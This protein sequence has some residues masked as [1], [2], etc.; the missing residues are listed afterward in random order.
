MSHN[1][2]AR[3]WKARAEKAEAAHNRLVEAMKVVQDERDELR[4][5][6]ERL[7][8]ALEWYADTHHIYL[9][10]GQNEMLRQALYTHAFVSHIFLKEVET[11][12][13]A[14]EALQAPES[15]PK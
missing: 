13:R 11:G 2:D 3:A 10:D 12:Q 14:R 9:H 1:L 4:A 8:R 15:E 6:N 7:R 5:E